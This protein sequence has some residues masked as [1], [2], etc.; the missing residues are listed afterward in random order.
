MIT[1][2]LLVVAVAVIGFA[3]FAGEFVWNGGGSDSN[4]TTP[5]NWGKT[6][7]GDYPKTGED[8]A[9]FNGTAG[10]TLDTGT[11]TT[12]SYLKV[13]A[14]T[15]TIDGTTGSTLNCTKAAA[16]DASGLVVTSGATLIV[17]VPMP[18]TARMDKWGTGT[19]IVRDAAVTKYDAAAWYLAHGT[20]IFDG[21]ASVSFPYATICFGNGTPYD[22]MP[23]FIR[24][25]A[26]WNVKG[27]D[28]AASTP[29]SPIVDIVQESADSVVNAGASG[30][31]LN[32]KRATEMQR[33][34]LKSGTLA[35]A[36]PLTLLSTNNPAAILYVQ[37]GGTSTFA[38]V[39]FT[40]GS[41]ALRGGVMNFTGANDDFKMGSGT[42]FEI[43][44]GTLAWPR[45]FNP[46]G[47]PQIKS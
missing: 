32:S 17:K 29:S 28:T 47:W 40:S 33:Y 19:L 26:T 46:S 45:T 39:A 25:S 5:Q 10:V 23:V 12:I 22:Y 31:T 21:T 41:A 1:K 11:D 43:S 16:G 14:G 3:A 24:D 38:K 34:T 15:V 44:G 13:T 2:S 27:I 20:N 37:E 42:T 9:V 35:V 18:F 4:W 8:I 30:M 36:G 7:A 6:S